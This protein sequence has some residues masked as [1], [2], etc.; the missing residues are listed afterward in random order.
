MITAPIS[1]IACVVQPAGTVGTNVPKSTDP[2]SGLTSIKFTK[3][4]PAITAINNAKNPYRRCFRKNVS[5]FQFANT[6]VM[7]EQKDEGVNDCND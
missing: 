7:Y 1:P 4:H 3:K 6:K 5:Y 2:M